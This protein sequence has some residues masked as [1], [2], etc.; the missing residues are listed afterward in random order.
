MAVEVGG[1]GVA[2]SEAET[3]GS[4]W[5]SVLKGGVGVLDEQETMRLM[6]Q[7]ART[8]GNLFIFSL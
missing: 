5:V 7:S 1:T 2:V 8:N 6:R 3:I 4:A